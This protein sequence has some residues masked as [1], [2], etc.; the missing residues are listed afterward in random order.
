MIISMKRYAPMEVRMSRSDKTRQL[1][2]EV[3]KS[4]PLREASSRTLDAAEV[5]ARAQ[6][7]A[8]VRADH[9]AFM[10]EMQELEEMAEKRIGRIS[11]SQRAMLIAA[12]AHGAELEPLGPLAGPLR[13]ENE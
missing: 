8:K 13:N 5:E 9:E 3:P 1:Q 12:A 2:P 10:Q 4:L 7:L 11:E 6:R